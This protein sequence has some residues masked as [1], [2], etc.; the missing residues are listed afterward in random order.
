MLPA[1]RTVR[2]VAAAAGAAA[3]TLAFGI[4]AVAGGALEQHSGTALY[5]SLVYALVVFV[6]PRI[7]PVAAALAATGFC[8]AV[9]F[10]Q[11]TP[12]PAALSERSIVARLVLGVAFDPVDLI[13]YP[14]G[15]LVF[16]SLHLLALQAAGK[17]RPAGR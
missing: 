10:A 12:V 1:K 5:A 4:R 6:W 16:M 13:W 8:W 17:R 7:N 14:L 11:L 2:L 3:L 15:A 9:E